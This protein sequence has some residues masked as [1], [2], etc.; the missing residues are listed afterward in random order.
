MSDSE[1][2]TLSQ[3]IIALLV[4]ERK[5]QKLTQADLAFMAGW[6][7]SFVTKIEQGLGDR[8]ISVYQRYAQALGKNLI[9]SMTDAS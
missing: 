3:Q 6:S 2:P 8:Q 1:V 5:R 4:V 9:V 7:K